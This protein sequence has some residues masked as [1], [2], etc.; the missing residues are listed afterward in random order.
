MTGWNYS[1]A[2]ETVICKCRKVQIFLPFQ[3]HLIS[4]IWDLWCQTVN[5]LPLLCKKVFYS[6]MMDVADAWRLMLSVD[7]NK[8]RRFWKMNLT[9]VLQSQGLY[10]VS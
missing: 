6:I 1:A 7:T 3:V 2:T 10:V 4:G 9:D 8:G 5:T